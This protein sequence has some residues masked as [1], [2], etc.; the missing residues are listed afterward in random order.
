MPGPSSRNLKQPITYWAPTGETNDFNEY[1]L[2]DPVLLYGKWEL[3]ETIVRNQ[4]GDELVCQN[5]VFLGQEVSVNGWLA[6]GDVTSESDPRSDDA[7]G[8]QIQQFFS[9]P[10]LRNMEQERRAVC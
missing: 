5:V 2:E 4:H 1:L 9:T 6:Q 7:Q 10:D 8:V 3:K